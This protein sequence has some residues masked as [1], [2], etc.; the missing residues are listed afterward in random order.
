MS[1][2]SSVVL[3]ISVSVSLAEERIMPSFPLAALQSW[4]TSKSQRLASFSDRIR[5]M[6]HKDVFWILSMAKGF[7]SVGWNTEDFREKSWRRESEETADQLRLCDRHFCSTLEWLIQELTNCQNE[8][9]E[10][11]IREE[12]R[13]DE[14]TV[15]RVGDQTQVV[16]LRHAPNLANADAKG[17]VQVSSRRALGC[18]HRKK[19]KKREV[20]MVKNKI[21]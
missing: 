5:L 20:T 4:S 6:L 9:L 3:I 14:E 16:I 15:H 21:K 12:A 7:F 13:F 17:G 11:L 10:G 18:F 1:C 2:K 8:I 19:K